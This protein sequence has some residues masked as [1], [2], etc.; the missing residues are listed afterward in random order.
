MEQ[1]NQGYPKSTFPSR[2]LR[3]DSPPLALGQR[4]AN[5]AVYAHA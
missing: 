2:R 5:V 3:I 4:A 1:V